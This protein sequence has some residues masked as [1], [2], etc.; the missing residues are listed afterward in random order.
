VTV[1]A[2]LLLAAALLSHSAL[3]STTRTVDFVYI[4]AN[5]GGSSGGHTAIRF[6]DETYHFQHES[7]GVLRLRRDDWQDF[8]Y[9]YGVLE[10]RTMHVSRIAVPDEVWERLRRRFNERFLAERKLFEHRDTL[11]DDRLLLELLLARRRGDPGGVVR[12][13]GAG[14]FFPDDGPSTPSAAA[15]ALRQRVLDTYGPDAIR[16]RIEQVRAELAQLSPAGF[17]PPSDDVPADGQPDFSYPFSRRYLD[18]LTA[19]A[20]LRALER[21]L[22]LRPGSY[23][24]TTDRSFDLDATARRRLAAWGDRLTDALVRLVRSDR[25]DWG[26]AFLVGM[27]RLEALHASGETGRLVLLDVFPSEPETIPR[28]EVRRHRD[29]LVRLRDDVHDDFMRSRARLAVGAEVDETAFAETEATGNRLLELDAARAEDRDVRLASGS[30]M[31]ARDAP[32]PALTLPAVAEDDLARRLAETRVAADVFAARLEE[33]YAYDLVGRNCASEIFHTVD[34]AG[35]EPGGHV[36]TRWSLAFIPF[37]AAR[38]VNQ[39]WNVVRRETLASYRR[40]R[41]NDMYRHETALRVRLRES[42]VLTSTAYRRNADDSFFLFFTDDLVALRPL[43]GAVNLASGI[44]AAA[45]GI[46]LLPFDRGE[47]LRS[48]LRGVLFSLP[49]L[50]FVNLR[51]G[52]FD[53]VPRA[54]AAAQ[55]RDG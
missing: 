54:E 12:V 21:A 14:Y 38:A 34:G 31:P 45:V 22:P 17:A 41:L 11:R 20:A 46:P 25:P 3:A 53:Y 29:A 19:S 40:A 47:T 37:V 39:A 7:P 13:R 35:V 8:R 48:G 4:E 52:S 24:S 16:A 23:W 33:R 36:E 42:N 2:I 26:F 44:G 30:L 5:E 28:S 51:K 18:L 1:R 49:E 32:W 50:A 55:T 10:N 6:G 15:H 27:A 43:F 9:A